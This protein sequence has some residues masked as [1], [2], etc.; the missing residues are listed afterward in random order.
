[1]NAVLKPVVSEALI[2]L[3]NVDKTYE[4]PQG[5]FAAISLS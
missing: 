2:E 1:M 3:R 5:G 4:G